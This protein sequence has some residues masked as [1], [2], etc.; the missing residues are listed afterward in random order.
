VL[1]DAWTEAVS[2]LA[3]ALSKDPTAL[4]GGGASNAGA[5]KSA[6][7]GGLSVT[8]K[9]EATATSRYGAQAPLVLQ[10]FPWLGDVLGCW[11]KVSTG[12]VRVLHRSCY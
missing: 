5:I 10:R 8:Y 11:L 12:S 4:V 3:L 6:S 9:D 1:A 7:L 2:E